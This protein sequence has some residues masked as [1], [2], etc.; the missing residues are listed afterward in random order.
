M[1]TEIEEELGGEQPQTGNDPDVTDTFD[2]GINFQHLVVE[3]INGRDIR[4]MEE[5]YNILNQNPANHTQFEPPAVL[6]PTYMITA[7]E[8]HAAGDTGTTG[9]VE[10]APESATPTNV[11]D[12]MM[13]EYATTHMSRLPPVPPLVCSS[14]WCWQDR[15]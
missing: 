15:R 2:D 8:D 10:M 7:A 3:T 1:A 11:A 12:A 4:S 13:Q 5:F 9:D 6:Y 14:G